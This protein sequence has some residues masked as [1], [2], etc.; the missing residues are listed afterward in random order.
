MFFLKQNFLTFVGGHLI[1]NMVDDAS[2]KNFKQWSC[3]HLC[4]D[5]RRNPNKDIHFRLS[6]IISSSFFEKILMISH[7]FPPWV[8]KKW[9]SSKMVNTK[10]FNLRLLF[11]RILFFLLEIMILRKLFSI[12]YAF[13]DL[14]S[15]SKLPSG[16]YFNTSTIIFFIDC[17]HSIA[18]RR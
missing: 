15:R 6:C 18:L 9:K 2:W 5:V 3:F 8:E 17:P 7:Q 11:V 4:I 13:K 16:V 10:V 12:P 1:W 14:T